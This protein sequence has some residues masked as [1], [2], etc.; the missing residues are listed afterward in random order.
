MY[1][2]PSSGIWRP[3]RIGAALALCFRA[4]PA[5]HAPTDDYIRKLAEA[6]YAINGRTMRKVTRNKAAIYL[7]A[8]TGLR[9]GEVTKLRRRDIDLERGTVIAPKIKNGEARTVS[10]PPLALTWLQNLAAY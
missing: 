8:L 3:V 2:G 1:S 4:L 9:T 7:I 10:L 6:A 5:F